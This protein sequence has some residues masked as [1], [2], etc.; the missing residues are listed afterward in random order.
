MFVSPNDKPHGHVHA[1][2]HYKYTLYINKH[3]MGPLIFQP[4]STT[5]VF[6][7]EA[8]LNCLGITVTNQSYIHE[9][10]KGRVHS[11]NVATVHFRISFLPSP[12]KEHKD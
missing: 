6:L 11:E 8:K 9:E 5:T 4:Y 3:S 12:V 7:T 2:S 10:T 1:L